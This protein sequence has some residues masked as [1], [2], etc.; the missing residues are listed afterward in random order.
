MGWYVWNLC[1]EIYVLAFL[2]FP[3]YD[4]HPESY[5]DVKTQNPT[6]SIDYYFDATTFRGC[7]SILTFSS[8]YLQS[9]RGLQVSAPILTQLASFGAMQIR[10]MSTGVASPRIGIVIPGFQVQDLEPVSDLES[11]SR[12]WQS[13]N[14]N[15]NRV[16][17]LRSSLC[18]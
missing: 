10:N 3:S 15:Q 7:Q 16:P 8:Y 18:Y 14:W 4:S 6:F 2:Q 12:V 5:I 13:R 1:N 17:G 11:S 9:F